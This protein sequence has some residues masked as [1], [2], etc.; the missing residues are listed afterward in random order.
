MSRDHFEG[1]DEVDPN[2]LDSGADDPDS[3]DDADSEHEDPSRSESLTT[4]PELDALIVAE[5][6]KRRRL[7]LA[8][9]AGG[10]INKHG[11]LHRF[12]HRPL[13]PTGSFNL[14]Q[15]D[16]ARCLHMFRCALGCATVLSGVLVFTLRLPC[17]SGSHA[18]K[19]RALPRHSAYR[20]FLE[21]PTASCARGRMGSVC[22]FGDW[23][24]QVALWM[25][26]PSFFEVRTSCRA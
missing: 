11:R 9:V 26:A 15:L 10:L 5:I 6:V 3:G 19:S 21:P 7:M 24:I 1:V 23:R 12:H 13:V 16:D 22:C 14:N 2:S 20:P 18:L 25:A 17:L 8:A 4:L